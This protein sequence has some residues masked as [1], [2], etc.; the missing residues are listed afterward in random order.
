[1]RERDSA[2][3]W[4]L[5]GVLAALAVTVW[6]GASDESAG[7]RVPIATEPLP[8]TSP[9]GG[10]PAA[11]ARETLAFIRNG[12]SM[13]S[14]ARSEAGNAD[15]ALRRADKVDFHT[16]ILGPASRLQQRWN[17]AVHP[18]L[19][20]FAACALALAHFVDQADGVFNARE[21]LVSPSEREQATQ[22]CIVAQ[23]AS[24]AS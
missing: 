13:L 6:G 21:M 22:R 9:T 10:T 12:D 18:E 17:I 3:G 1:M 2:D 11:L 14:T 5:L 4:T 20:P 7:A 24:P 23:E 19:A 15:F 16:F 8:S